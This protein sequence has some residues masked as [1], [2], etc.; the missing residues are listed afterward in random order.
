M[1]TSHTATSVLTNIYP[2]LPVDIVHI[3]YI[4]LYHNI[5]YIKLGRDDNTYKGIELMLPRYRNRTG[6]VWCVVSP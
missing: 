2:Y 5:Y 3:Y 1:L 6:T 4:K